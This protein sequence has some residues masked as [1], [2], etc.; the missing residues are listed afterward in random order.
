MSI[1]SFGPKPE[2]TPTV[3]HMT[4]EEFS[5]HANMDTESPELATWMAEKGISFDSGDITINVDGEER[6]M[7]TEKNDFGTIL[8]Q[9]TIELRKR[10]AGELSEAA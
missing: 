8:T 3:I 1:E 6:V 4:Q 10:Q 5:T 7:V 2:K 9:E